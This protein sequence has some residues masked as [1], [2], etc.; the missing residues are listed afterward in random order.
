MAYS[1][2][3]SAIISTAAL[4]CFKAPGQPGAS[5][6]RPST[7]LTVLGLTVLAPGCPG[8]PCTGIWLR[9]VA[10]LL[11]H[12]WYIVDPKMMHLG[13]GGGGG[14]HISRHTGTFRLFGSIFCKK[15]LDMGTTF[16][17]KIPRHGSRHS[18]KAPG[19]GWPIW[20]L[21]LFIN[22]SAEYIL[23]FHMT[24]VYTTL[25]ICWQWQT[26]VITIFQGITV[27]NGVVL[28]YTYRKIKISWLDMGPLFARN[29]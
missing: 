12:I 6:V 5:T 13:P 17:W 4:G 10:S 21:C 24:L 23:L 3:T 2:Y 28:A 26:I 18:I 25:L 14:T 16:H 11:I 1:I 27:N 29:P 22:L 8:R 9:A 19:H 7:G 15:S 20:L